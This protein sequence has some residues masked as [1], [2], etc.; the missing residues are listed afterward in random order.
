MECSLLSWPCFFTRHCL[1]ETDSS[2][3]EDQRGHM[4]TWCRDSGL[5]TPCH[6]WFGLSIFWGV[7]VGKKVSEFQPPARLLS[8]PPTFPACL[9]YVPTVGT[10]KTLQSTGGALSEWADG[11]F[12]SVSPRAGQTPPN[13]I[14]IRSFPFILLL[15]SD[16]FQ[17]LNTQFF[18]FH[19]L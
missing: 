8:S 2:Q 4:K 10:K 9:V 13:P 11:S 16:I 3:S 18:I 6:D 15:V 1:W 12:L 5:W 7:G 14:F 19:I 17:F